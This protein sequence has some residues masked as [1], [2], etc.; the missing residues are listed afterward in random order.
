MLLSEAKTSTI[1]RP[2]VITITPNG[3]TLILVVAEKTQGI[4]YCRI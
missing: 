4:L 2:G 1:L 3:N